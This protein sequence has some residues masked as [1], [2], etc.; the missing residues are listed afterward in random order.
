[1]VR[2]SDKWIG[3]IGTSKIFLGYWKYVYLKNK[4]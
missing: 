1:M 2:D 3:F 4:K